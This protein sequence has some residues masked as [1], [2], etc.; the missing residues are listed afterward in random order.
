M[1]LAALLAGARILPTEQPVD[2]AGRA[3]R[4]DH[5]LMGDLEATALSF[6]D[7]ARWSL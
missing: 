3:L 4:D 7:R 5:P 1:G 6:F 2:M